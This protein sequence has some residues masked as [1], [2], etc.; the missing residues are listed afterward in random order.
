MT[1]FVFEGISR[2]GKSTIRD[3]IKKRNPEWIIFKGENLMRKGVTNNWV[4][5]RERYHEFLHRLY[6]LNPDNVIIADRGF[7]DIVYNFDPRVRHD[8]KRLAACYGDAHIIY[9]YPGDFNVDDGHLDNGIPILRRRG[10]RDTWQ[11]GAL[12]Y[13]YEELLEMFPYRHINTFEYDEEE[14]MQLVEKFINRTMSEEGR[15][16]PDV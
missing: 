9:F 2:S 6:E 1:L 13:R 14:S 11:L 5:Y 10:T 16:D 12:C 4:E 8:M 15:P 3:A 7:S